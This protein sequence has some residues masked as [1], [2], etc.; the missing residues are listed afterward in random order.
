MV[1]LTELAEPQAARALRWPAAARRARP[2]ARDEAEGAAPRRAARRP[3]PA[4]PAADARRAAQPPAPARADVHP[5]HAQPG[6]GALHGRPDRGHER[7]PDPADRRPVDDRDAAGDR[8]RRPV[9]GRQQHHPRQGDVERDGGRLVVEDEHDVRGQRRVP[10]TERRR[11]SATT[12]LVASAP[13]PSRWPR[14]RER[15]TGRNSADCEIIFVEFL[16]R[17]RQAPPHRRRRAH[18]REG[19]RR[20]VPD[21]P[22]PGGRDDPDLLEGGGCPAPQRLSPERPAP[23]PRGHRGGRG[24]RSSTS[25]SGRSARSVARSSER[26]RGWVTLAWAAPGLHLARLLPRSRRS[27]SS[28][29]MSFWTPDTPRASSRTGRR[30]TTATC[31]IP[32][33]STTPTGRTCGGRS[34]SPLIAVVACLIFGF[35]VAYFLAMK[36]REAAVPDRPLHPRAG[37]VLDELPH[38]V[39]RLGVPADGPRG[40]AQPVPVEARHL[41]HDHPL[42][43]TQFSQLSVQ[44]AMIQ[45]YILFMVTPIFFLLAQVDRHAIEAARDLGGNWWQHLPGGDPPADDAGHRH[46]LDLHLRADDGRVRHRAGDQPGRGHDGRASY[47]QSQIVGIQYPQG[48]AS[49]VLLVLVLILG[50]FAITRF[51]NLREEHLSVSRRP[52]HPRWSGRRTRSSSG[53]TSP[54]ATGRSGASPPTSSSSWSSCTRR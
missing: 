44:L 21:A 27:S 24:R 53:S 47:I 8:A 35:P 40:G 5:R 39:G 7:G 28:S 22:R 3:R 13:R 2:R 36:V 12:A 46:R 20:A 4:A 25:T 15:T 1:G 9:H 10:R 19:A 45:L 54:G 52:T 32:S 23:R 33:A 31:S 29:S 50:V 26:G 34:R 38:A 14:R 11:P 18:A 17:P 37:A 49:A 51:S 48:A 43:D 16:G 41:E 42:L 30:R 6:R